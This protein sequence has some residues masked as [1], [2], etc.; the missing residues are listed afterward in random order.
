[1]LL[2]GLMTVIRRHQ[3]AVQMDGAA[4]GRFEVSEEP[5][6]QRYRGPIRAST[7]RTPTYIAPHVTRTLATSFSLRKHPDRPTLRGPDPLSMTFSP[8][9]PTP[10]LPSQGASPGS[11]CPQSPVPGATS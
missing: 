2:R 7:P 11:P 8:L 9:A 5:P 4:I 6:A 1:M 3:L 10:S